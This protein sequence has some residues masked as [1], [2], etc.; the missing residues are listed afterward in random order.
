MSCLKKKK[1]YFDSK[2]L[3]HLYDFQ[4]IKNLLG[5]KWFSEIQI[6]LYIDFNDHS[7]FK[8]W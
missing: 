6:T 7:D 1:I 5:K 2:N 8:L 3:K 4:Y